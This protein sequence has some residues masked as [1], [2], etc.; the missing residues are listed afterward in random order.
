MKKVVFHPE[1]MKVHLRS[2]I[3]LSLHPVVDDFSDHK[4]TREPLALGS[5]CQLMQYWG[6]SLS[7]TQHRQTTHLE[8]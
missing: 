5:V 4:L 3:K 2:V 8:G 6:V 7:T 1:I